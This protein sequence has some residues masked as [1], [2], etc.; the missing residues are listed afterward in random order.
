MV[1]LGEGAASASALG[2]A[3][4]VLLRRLAT[5]PLRIAASFTV[6]DTFLHPPRSCS[7]A[8][9]SRHPFHSSL[10]TDGV[11]SLRP[12]HSVPF[13][14]PCG[15]VSLIGQLRRTR[16]AAYWNPFHL[17]RRARV[18]LPISPIIWRSPNLPTEVVSG[19]RPVLVVPPHS[20]VVLRDA[21]LSSLTYSR[22]VSQN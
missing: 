17:A 5:A 8:P 21:R 7:D 13:G 1:S 18:T 10:H 9:R 2:S 3:R 12:T 14:T 4:G 22:R 6:G 15:C 19:V 16:C 20:S 11:S